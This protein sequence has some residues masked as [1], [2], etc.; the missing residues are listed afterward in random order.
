MCSRLKRQRNTAFQHPSP[1]RL[2]TLTVHLPF[3]DTVFD[4]VPRRSYNGKPLANGPTTPVPPRQPTLHEDSLA[5]EVDRLLSARNH[6]N[7][8]APRTTTSMPEIAMLLETDSS[9]TSRTFSVHSSGGNM[10]A[11]R[12]RSAIKPL[13]DM[14]IFA[15][16]PPDYCR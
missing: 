9:Y 2:P 6:C 10:N 5:G 12:N 14:V 7:I 15:S 4:P 11:G 1:K 8:S 3:Y 13:W 16:P